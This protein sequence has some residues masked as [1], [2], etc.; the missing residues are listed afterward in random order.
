MKLRWWNRKPRTENRELRTEN[1]KPI[2]ENRHSAFG[3]RL[4]PIGSLF[5]ALCFLCSVLSCSNKPAWEYMPDMAD[6]PALKAQ[7]YDVNLPHHRTLL[8]PVPGTIA[9]DYQPYPYAKEEA[10]QAGANLKNPLPR[11]MEVM[12]AGEKVYKI[13]CIVC[14]GPTGLGNGTVVPPFPRPPSLHSEKTKNWPD[15]R[16]Y[17]VVTMGQ[18]L[19]PAYASQIQPEL[20]WAVVHYIRALQKAEGATLEDIEAYQEKR[21]ERKEKND[22]EK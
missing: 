12:L 21:G 22:G 18:N 8:T 7:K 1:R 5:S 6:Q 15:G 10:L 3:A 16:I 20:R 14:H 2:T 17:H 19:M 9:K 13:N 11:T 4:S